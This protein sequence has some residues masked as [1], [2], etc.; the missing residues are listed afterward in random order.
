MGN[1][2]NIGNIDVPQDMVVLE[3]DRGREVHFEYLDLIEYEGI[4]YAVLFPL[5]D[6]SNQ[7]VILRVNSFDGETEE[8]SGVEDQDILQAVFDIFMER[9]SM[10]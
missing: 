6:D 10:L 5:D 3:D 9:C 7:V 4:E 8:L 1:K 2:N